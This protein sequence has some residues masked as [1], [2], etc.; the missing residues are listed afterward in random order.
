MTAL[1]KV[2]A[3]KLE[4]NKPSELC[5]IVCM[6]ENKNLTGE[7]TATQMDLMNLLLYKSREKIIKENLET[8]DEFFNLEVELH[9]F[10]SM[11]GK[12]NNSD[13]KRVIE[14]LTNLKSQLFVINALGKNKDVESTVTS[15]VHKIKFSR[16]RDNYKKLARIVLDGEII[17]MVIKTKKFFSKMF[18]SIQFSMVSKY[19]KSLYELLKDYENIKHLTV[20]L[21]LLFGLLNVDISKKTNTKWSTFRANILN[22]AV[23]EINEKSDIVVSYE[24]IKEKIEN[25]RKQVTKVKFSIKKQN[26]L[27]LQQLGLIEESITAHE[28]YTKSKAKMDKLVKSGYKVI[29]EEMWI[30]TD[31]TKN[32]KK[33]K[34][35]T[36][37]DVWMKETEKSDKNKLFKKLA[38]S[39]DNCDDPVVSIED[40][41]IKGVYT[42]DSFTKTPQETIELLNNI[43]AEMG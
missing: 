18:L 41:I 7:L 11:L 35:E 43:I 13:Y 31:I 39:I 3:T 6:D 28:F 20:E 16:H 19:S 2:N 29:D 10:N 37:I 21:E 40:Y 32:E 15:F 33:Y 22:K 14:H 25:Q 38:N 5:Q 26:E 36:R 8:V 9:Y 30:T 27:K 34:S 12:N 42:K 17:S 23:T 1:Q 4:I 24:P